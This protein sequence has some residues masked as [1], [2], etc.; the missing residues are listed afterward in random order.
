MTKYIL[1][2]FKTNGQAGGIRLFM[3]FLDVPFE[4]EFIE[5]NEWLTF[6][7]C[8]KSRE[9]FYDFLCFS[10]LATPFGQLPVL[11]CREEN[12]VL[13]E[14][15]AIYR[16]LAKKHDNFPKSLEE[17]VLCDSFGHHIQKY[18]FKDELFIEA[19]CLRKSKIVIKKLN[20]N[21]T[22]FLLEQLI[23][24]LNKQLKKNGNGNLIGEKLTWIDFFI[25]NI[26]DEY[27]YRTEEKGKDS[28]G[29]VI[30]HHE[31]IFSLPQL[32]K[33]IE[34]RETLYPPREQIQIDFFGK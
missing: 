26:I 16:F 18:L 13:P 5:H 22:K 20:E 30:Q 19:R 15:L 1:Q 2:Y 32:Q 4:N 34:K 7:Q 21:S 27:L 8:K 28:L 14:T 31:K 25:A 9:F 12:L 29:A 11:I 10:F 3:D 17:Q 24:D 33:G 6:K 23:P